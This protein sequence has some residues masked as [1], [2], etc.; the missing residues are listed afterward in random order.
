MLHRDGRQ[1][2]TRPDLMTGR[3]IVNQTPARNLA[4]PST[5]VLHVAIFI[6][7]LSCRMSCVSSLFDT[8]PARLW[9]AISLHI[10]QCLKPPCELALFPGFFLDQSC[11]LYCDSDV[12]AK[13]VV[14]CAVAPSARLTSLAAALLPDKGWSSWLPSSDLS[15]W[16]LSSSVS[17]FMSGLVLSERVF[18]FSRWNKRGEEAL[19]A[20][21][22]SSARFVDHSCTVN[23]AVFQLFYRSLI[24]SDVLVT[25]N[26][27]PVKDTKPVGEKLDVT[28]ST[29]FKPSFEWMY[30]CFKSPVL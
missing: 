26:V 5:I 14:F 30:S 29:K 4:S 6:R 18:V 21:S 7:W 11:F 22:A 17:V 24:A 1:V 12:L 23:E 27:W 3:H 13:R 19:V 20:T 15:E 9:Q 10:L 8:E 2:S 16:P 28:D 25:S